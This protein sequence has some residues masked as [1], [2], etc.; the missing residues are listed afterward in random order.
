MFLN[1]LHYYSLTTP[2]TATS[3]P[4]DDGHAINFVSPF[5]HLREGEDLGY[6]M[7]LVNS[8]VVYYF[9][10][11]G[12]VPYYEETDSLGYHISLRLLKEVCELIAGGNDVNS[13][14]DIKTVGKGKVEGKVEGKAGGSEKEKAEVKDD[15]EEWQSKARDSHMKDI[16]N[17]RLITFYLSSFT[18]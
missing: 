6:N 10:A 15:I 9:V 3:L 1:D 18:A 5:C 17:V 14:M 2:T 4:S 7:D 16:S 8:L 12:M 13:V 11:S